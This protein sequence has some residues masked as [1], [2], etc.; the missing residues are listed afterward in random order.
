MNLKNYEVVAVYN[1][2]ILHEF[3]QIQIIEIVLYLNTNLHSTV[4]FFSCS[5]SLW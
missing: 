4:Y 3:A 2:T 1:S 5:V